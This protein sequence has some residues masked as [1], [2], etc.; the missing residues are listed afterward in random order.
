MSDGGQHRLSVFSAETLVF[1][2]HIGRKGNGAGELNTPEGL[3]IWHGKEGEGDMGASQAMNTTEHSSTSQ[4]PR[5][6][7]CRYLTWYLGSTFASLAMVRVDGL[8]S[9]SSRV[10]SRSTC[11]RV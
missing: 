10:A 8:G 2:R 6:T 3:A 7:G 4:I 1:E 11:F 9:S 5:I